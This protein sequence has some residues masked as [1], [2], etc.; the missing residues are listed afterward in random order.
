VT[1]SIPVVL[2]TWGLASLAVSLV[3]GAWLARRDPGLV[4]VQ[5]RVPVEER[6]A[7]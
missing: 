3:V 2:A 6:R 7:A 5:E 4:M 1:V